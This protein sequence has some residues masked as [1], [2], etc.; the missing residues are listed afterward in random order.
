M[1]K[2]INVFHISQVEG[3]EPIKECELNKDIE[4]IETAEKLLNDYWTREKI[5]VNHVMGFFLNFG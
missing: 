5:E 3:V 4:P 1:L 2:Y